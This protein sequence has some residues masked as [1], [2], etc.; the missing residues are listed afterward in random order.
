M[1]R[2]LAAGFILI[3]AAPAWAVCSP[4]RI[5]PPSYP[6]LAVQARRSAVITAQVTVDAEG[7]PHARLSDP[8]SLFAPAIRAA[9][10][11]TR[12]SPADC[13][14]AEFP[15]VF[16]FT[17]RGSGTHQHDTV[18]TFH[19]PNEFEIFARPYSVQVSQCSPL[20]W[21]PALY[22]PIAQA[23]RLSGT[24]LA[25]ITV[26]SDGKPDAELSGATRHFGSAV[27]SAIARSPL[28]PFGCAGATF[29][30]AYSFELEPDA[31]GSIDSDPFLL[32]TVA[33][34]AYITAGP[35]RVS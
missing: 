12:L 19:A 9:F 32:R 8:Q 17:I 11:R 16:R 7:Y 5:D 34:P 20:H 13:A 4:E 3:L 35:N 23:A 1:P 33:P 29:L 25:K 18:A 31:R 21:E 15:V 24:V 28:S 10:A 26:N 22:P 14:G 30:V 2:A 27:E 6:P